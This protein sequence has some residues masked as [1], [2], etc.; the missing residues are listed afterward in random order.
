MCPREGGQGVLARWVGLHAR[1]TR[2]SGEEATA[3]AGGGEREAAQGNPGDSSAQ[4]AEAAAPGDAWR[5]RVQLEEGWGN[6]GPGHAGPFRSVERCGFHWDGDRGQW[7]VW[8]AGCH[9]NL[10]EGH[11]TGLLRKGLPHGALWVALF[12]AQVSAHMP[13]YQRASPATPSCPWNL[14]WVTLWPTDKNPW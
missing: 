11:A 6:G 8:A 4:G 7:S 3:R 12:P 10:A 5:H 9:A 14:C 13:P 2:L 1:Q